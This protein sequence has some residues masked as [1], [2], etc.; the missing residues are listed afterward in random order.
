LVTDPIN[1]GTAKWLK[2]EIKKRF[3]KRIKYLVYSHDHQDHN[4]GDEVFADATIIG[5]YKIRAAMPGEKRPTPA[6]T[7]TFSDQMA[8]NLGGEQIELTYVGLGY[9][10]NSIVMRFPTD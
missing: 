4:S 5:H 10:D 9:S 3:N 8:I 7:L 2:A 1:T 6:P